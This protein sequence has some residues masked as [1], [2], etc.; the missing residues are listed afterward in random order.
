M[1]TTCTHCNTRFR[2][3]AAALTA[4]QGQVRCGKCHEVFDAYENL[5]GADVAPQMAEQPPVETEPMPTETEAMPEEAASVADIALSIAEDR[6]AP[7]LDTPMEADA[8]PITSAPELKARRRKAAEDLLIDDLFASLP[9][10]QEPMP[11]AEPAMA[12][13]ET[14]VVQPL[15]E[16]GDISAEPAPMSYAHVDEL[17]PP[18]AAPVPP[19]RRPVR[20]FALWSGILVLLLLL[21]V[22]L[23]DMDRTALSQNPVIGPSLQALYASLG[24]PISKP[25][26][27]SDWEVGALNVTTDPD[28]SGALSITGTL[29]NQ[30]GFVQ[31]WPSLRVVLTDRFGE[32]LRAR[33]FKPADYLPAGQSASLIAPGLTARFRLDVVDPGPD[34]VGFSLTP[35][36]DAPTGR[37]C[38]APNTT[39]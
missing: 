16:M 29:A 14:D 25:L 31:P 7:E 5:E 39:D 8:E 15:G 37:I 38:A 32:P 36:L 2:L 1:F 30:A 6:S 11:E 3:S 9:D 35:C 13:A 17:H 10:E 21:G 23:V 27:A 18:P 28:S 4:A 33:D 24:R 19:P 12:A 26:A 20:S 22:Q 34:A